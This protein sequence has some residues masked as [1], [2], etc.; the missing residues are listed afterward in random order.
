[1]AAE[2]STP[3]Q[4][5]TPGTLVAERFRV[6]ELLGAGGMGRVYA[7]TQ[8][9]P[10][11]PVALKLLPPDANPELVRRFLR[12]ADALARVTHP[13]VVR[14]FDAGEANVDG[15]RQLWI[16]MERLSGRTLAELLQAEGRLDIARALAF[17]RDAAR[18]LREAH[19]VGVVHRDLKPGNLF[20]VRTEDGES[21]RVLDFGVAKV[22]AEGEDQLTVAGTLIGSPRYTSP[23]QLG[24]G[25]VDGRADLYALGI[26]LHEMIAGAPP[27][28]HGDA[29]RTLVAQLR[30]PPPP[31]RSLREDVPEGVE[32]LV[33]RLLAKDP[34]DRPVD[35]Q[36]LLGELARVEDARRLP[37]TKVNAAPVPIPSAPATTERHGGWT[38]APPVARRERTHPGWT[39]TLLGLVA[40]LA[41][42]GIALAMFAWKAPRVTETATAP[43]EVPEA[44]AQTQVVSVPPGATV[45]QG[46]TRLG[47]TPLSL[48]PAARILRL[49][50]SGYR[51]AQV[52]VAPGEARVEVALEA[53]RAKK[54]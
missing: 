37:A 14:L 10:A 13:N 39:Q 30:D 9:S 50:R 49:T 6:G 34:A 18:A 31:L 8:L 40:I 29:M 19:A 11:R 16:A 12:E 46:R 2:P 44:N 28:A 53:T 4:D 51:D 3:E 5:P 7:A 42:V 41:G 26:V 35:A 47:T 21:L 23:E 52:A 22:R 38:E 48:P 25:E 36:T 24:D 32:A 33:L 15:R 1:M 20:V 54:R 43:L 45:W 27:F 17:T